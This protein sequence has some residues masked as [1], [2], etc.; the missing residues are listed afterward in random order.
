MCACIY[1]YMYVLT[2]YNHMYTYM[3][4]TSQGYHRECIQPY[5]VALKLAALKLYSKLVQVMLNASLL[6]LLPYAFVFW[7]FICTE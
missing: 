6:I 3:Y 7:G 4:L 5:T 1:T 2:Q